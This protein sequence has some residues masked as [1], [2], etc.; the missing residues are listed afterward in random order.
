MGVS[1]SENFTV[2]SVSCHEDRAGF[3]SVKEGILG[4]KACK[5]MCITMFALSE[6]AGVKGGLKDTEGNRLTR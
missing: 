4:M 1:A 2:A 3:P 6:V 5:S